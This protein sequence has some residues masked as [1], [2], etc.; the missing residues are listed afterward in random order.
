MKILVVGVSGHLGKRFLLNLDQLG[1]RAEIHVLRTAP[2]ISNC[3]P[4]F[5]VDSKT[6]KFSQSYLSEISRNESQFKFDHIFFIGSAVPKDDIE[7]RS[8]DID[9]AIR[10]ALLV[11]QMIEV[12]KL[13]V[14][15]IV[16]VSS[17]AVYGNCGRF[18]ISS[19]PNPVDAYGEYKLKIEQLFS[20]VC[21]KKEIPLDIVRPTLIFGPGESLIRLTT[22]LLRRV[23]H[24]QDLRFSG[25]DGLRNYVYVDDV[26]RYLTLL[27][28]QPRTKLCVRYHNLGNESSFQIRDYITMTLTAAKNLNWFEGVYPGEL[29]LKSDSSVDFTLQHHYEV[30]HYFRQES[31]PQNIEK[32]LRWAKMSDLLH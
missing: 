25:C 26:A 4:D 24:L 5:I 8:F 28:F 2:F 31:L 29:I 32:Y 13:K 10:P 9:K 19:I 7:M 18:A 20:T 21:S 6:L 17:A 1:L 27:C 16:Y 30:E 3:S 14:K 23:L 22:V 15:H 12:G 11:K